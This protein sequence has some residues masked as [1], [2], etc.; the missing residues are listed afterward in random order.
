MKKFLGVLVLVFL[1]NSCDDGDV[2]VDP[3]TFDEVEAEN[4]GQ[5][6][7]KLTENRAIII[8]LPE[9]TENI[10]DIFV[11]DLNETTP[12]ALTIGNNAN[13]IYRIY[14]GTVTD[15]ALC[16]SP[17][18]V[19]PVATEEW[20]ATAGTI[21]FVTTPVYTAPDTET[22]ATKITRYRHSIVFRDIK[23]AKPD[24][25]DQNYSEFNFG[26][27]FTNPLPLPF[28]FNS[29][30]VKLCPTTNTLYKALNSGKEGLFIKNL[31]PSLLATTNLGVPKTALISTTENALIYRLFI[32]PIPSDGNENYFCNGTNTTPP[33]TQEQWNGLP[34][35]ADV[36][37]IIEVTTTTNGS[38]FLHTIKLKGVTFKRGNTTFYYGNDML[39]G[40]LITN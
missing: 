35:V 40:E 27:F 14:N 1:L 38:G 19:S 32:D 13:V 33:A 8:K 7:Y 3:V 15:A 23:F 5:L 4:C 22:G 10:T 24:G 34:G 17:P 2:T 37:G 16:S 21:L 25:T 30:E 36:S 6:V 39:Y 29:A 31:S 12:R 18:P 11:N 20:L 26:N 9:G 28:N